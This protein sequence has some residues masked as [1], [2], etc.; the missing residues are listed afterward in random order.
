MWNI[1]YFLGKMHPLIELRLYYELVLHFGRKGAGSTL[2]T[3]NQLLRGGTLLT[4][5][6]ASARLETIER[7]ARER[8]HSGFSIHLGGGG[9]EIM[10]SPALDDPFP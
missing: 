9:E 4:R 1:K 3:N 10:L 7:K 2:K 8:L 6:A 5:A